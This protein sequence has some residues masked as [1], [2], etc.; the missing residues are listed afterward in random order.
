VN[1]GDDCGKAGAAQPLFENPERLA[2][3]P[4]T[5]RDE[6]A[7][8]ETEACKTG[9]V[10]NACLARR[11]RLAHPENRTPVGA[12][13]KSGERGGEAVRRTG[14]ARLDA[15]DLMQRAEHEPAAE[16]AVERRKA[17]GKQTGTSNGRP[18]G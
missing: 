18:R 6:P 15:A 8:V 3:L 16:Q 9:T 1:L 17:E 12:R 4:D 7:G 5:H 10:G 2:G 11:A 14:C 13:E